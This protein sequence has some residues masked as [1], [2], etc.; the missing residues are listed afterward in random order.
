M[1]SK[2]LDSKALSFIRMALVKV[3][4]N[5]VVRWVRLA[6]GKNVVNGVLTMTIVTC[7][8]MVE[9]SVCSEKGSYLRKSREK[10]MFLDLRAALVRIFDC[11]YITHTENQLI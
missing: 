2:G 6:H 7:G 4:S 11:V 9:H 8:A 5:S 10:A 1:K 3:L